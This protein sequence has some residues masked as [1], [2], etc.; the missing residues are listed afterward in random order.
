MSKILLS[1]LLV[2]LLVNSATFI[3]AYCLR[4]RTNAS[5]LRIARSAKSGE[6]MNYFVAGMLNQPEPAFRFITDQVQ[7]GITFADFRNTG[8]NAQ[9]TADAIID[10]IQRHR[11]TKV[12]VFTISVGD[13][14]ARYLDSCYGDSSE[15]QLEVIAINPCPSAWVLNDKAMLAASIGA[16]TAIFGCFLIGWLSIVPM[17]FLSTPGGNYSL[18]LLACQGTHI[19]DYPATGSVSQTLGIAIS[20]DDEFLDRDELLDYFDGLPIVSIPHCRHGDTIG[21]AAAYKE[22]VRQILASSKL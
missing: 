8:W 20:E 3:G 2:V 12:R 10:D 4:Y 13:Q 7:G 6:T 16:P 17:P 21:N 14:V 1:V 5:R 18:Y 11:Y 19:A 9:A 15:P 22:A